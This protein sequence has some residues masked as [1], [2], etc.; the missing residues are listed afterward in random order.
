[1][2]L[3]SWLG[4]DRVI[5]YIMCGENKVSVLLLLPPREK[6]DLERS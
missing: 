3:M 4:L 2:G 1:M 6:A 5:V